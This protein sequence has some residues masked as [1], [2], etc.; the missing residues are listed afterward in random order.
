MPIARGVPIVS[1]AIQ[2][3]AGAALMAAGVGNGLLATFDATVVSGAITAIGLA[4]GGAIV[5]VNGARTKAKAVEQEAS[6]RERI[7]NAEADRDLAE[8]VRADNDAHRKAEI[9]LARAEANARLE[10]EALEAAARIKIEADAHAAKLIMEAD[11]EHAR[12]VREAE[13]EKLVRPVLE[14]RIAD[15]EAALAKAL[16]GS[17]DR[18]R[19]GQKAI[20]DKVD[21]ASRLRILLVEDDADTCRQLTRFL[22]GH[23]FNVVCAATIPEARKAFNGRCDWI[24]VHRVVAGEDGLAYIREIKAKRLNIK[25]AMVTGHPG[26]DVLERADRAFVDLCVTKPINLDKLL[27]D[28]RALEEKAPRPTI[29]DVEKALADSKVD[30]PTFK[31]EGA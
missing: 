11:A 7:A 5:F 4:V 9:E 15:L 19:E 10:R 23:G 13:R 22:S 8:R 18:L 25:L 28:M 14:R 26:E 12:V 17:E 24:F 2:T 27:Q 31:A 20:E 16:A 6:R 29:G 30:F 21:R 1:H 3:T